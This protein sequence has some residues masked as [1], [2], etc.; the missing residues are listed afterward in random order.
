M[1]LYT[2]P[3]APNP[4]KIEVFLA[5]KGIEIEREII[6]LPKG[7]QHDPAFRARN[8]LGRLPVLELDD[9]TLVAESLPILEYLEELHPEP[10]L[11]GRTPVE[12]LRVRS[13]ERMIDTSILLPTA[14]LVHATR[15]PLPGVAPN[16][17]M[18]EWARSALV[19]PL[20]VLDARVGDSPFVAGD[21]VTIADGTLFA[22]MRF[23][24][25]FGVEVD[26][27]HRNLHR[28]YA[29]FEERQ[30]AKRPV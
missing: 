28:W 8:P 27:Q 2:F 20:S 29:S 18:A 12:R 3:L 16:E 11:I 14:R 23:G 21:R 9:G 26:A 25:L 4:T 24:K 13:L 15:S 7:E 30:S 19:L 1:K 17:G 6:S 5:E 10:S 22:A